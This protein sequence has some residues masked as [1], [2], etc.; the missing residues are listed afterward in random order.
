M[1]FNI[2]RNLFLQANFKIMDSFFVGFGIAFMGLVPP[3]MLNMSAVRI[4]LEDGLRE[5]LK[6]SVGACLVVGIHSFIAMTFSVYLNNHPSIIELLKVLS[7]LVFFALSG[8]FFM[9]SKKKFDVE[10]K[11]QKGN[12]ILNGF[13][14]SNMNMLGIPFYCGASLALS[15]KNPSILDGSAKFILVL[16]AILGAFTLFSIYSLFAK[17]VKTKLSFISENINLILA[18]F[19]FFLGSLVLL[20][21]FLKNI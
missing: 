6:F 13:I 19:F 3:G 4:A 17:I 11:K 16:G 7:V 20:K 2:K 14:M 15:A 10:V 21:I 8:F 9:Q 12:K 18:V 5:A 1:P